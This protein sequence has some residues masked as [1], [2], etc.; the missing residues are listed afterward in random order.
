MDPKTKYDQAKSERQKY[1][2]AVVSSSAKKKI[3][4]AGP[5]TGKTY[6]F[7]EVLSGAKIL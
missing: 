3:V 2:D 4:A 6:L 7:K 1:V 5:G